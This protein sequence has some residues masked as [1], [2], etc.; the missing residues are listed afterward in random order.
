MFRKKCKKYCIDINKRLIKHVKINNI[1]PNKEELKDLII[2]PNKY[3]T[4]NLPLI[5]LQDYLFGLYLEGEH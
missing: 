1:F 4:I 5:Y 2:I 3:I